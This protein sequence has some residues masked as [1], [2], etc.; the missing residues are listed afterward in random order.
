MQSFKEFLLEDSLDIEVDI[1]DMLDNLEV[2]YKVEKD[3]ITIE[4][5]EKEIVEKI[6]SKVHD[7]VDFDVY[8]HGKKIDDGNIDVDDDDEVDIDEVDEGDFTLVIYLYNTDDDPEQLDEVRRIVK[9]NAK[10][11]RRIKMKCKKG[12]RWTGSKCK[13][14]AGKEMVTKKRAIRK[15]VRTRKAKGAGYQR[16]INVLRKRAMKKRKSMVATKR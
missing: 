9:V 2:E 8:A 1:T 6:I 3:H 10:G 15:M 14:I 12:F 4:I 7:E 16:R 11:K 5:D 13:K